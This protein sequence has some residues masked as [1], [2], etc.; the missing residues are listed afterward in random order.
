[1]EAPIAIGDTETEKALYSIENDHG[2]DTDKDGETPR[3]APIEEAIDELDEL[4]G[5]IEAIEDKNNTVLNESIEESDSDSDSDSDSEVPILKY[6]RIKKLPPTLFNKDPISTCTFHESYFLFATH[7]GKIHIT[8]PT[9]EPLRNFKA[10]R[11]SILSLYT[12]GEYFASGSMDGTVV[13]GSIKDESDITA[14]DFQRPI[15]GVILDPNY[16]RTK[17]FITGGMSGKV[18]YSTWNWLGKRQDLVIEEGS[19]PIVSL[20]LVN[21]MLI[22]MNDFGITICQFSTRRVVKKIEKPEDSPRSDLYWPKVSFPEIDRILI[23]WGNYIWMLRISADESSKDDESLALKILPS[24]ASFRSVVAERK[25]VTVDHIYKL[26][27]LIS[28]ITSFKDDLWMVLTYEPPSTEDGKR[29]FHNPEIKLINSING[30]VEFEEEVGMNNIENLGLND[31]MIRS[32]IHS[33]GSPTSYYIISAK[34]GIVV[35][36]YQLQ[37]ILEWYI[38][39]GKY[40]EAWEISIHLVGW[41]KRLGYGINHVD[42]LIKDDSWSAAAQFLTSLLSFEGLEEEGEEN[43]AREEEMI[44]NWESFGNIFIDSGHIKE[45]SDVIPQRF[46][47]SASIYNKILEYCLEE[48]P[49]K[50]YKSIQ[51]DIYLYDIKKIQSL[52]E[53]KLEGDEKNKQLRRCLTDLYDKSNDYNKAVP[54]LIALKDWNLV[55]YLSKNHILDAYVDMLPKII[56]LRFTED[57]LTSDRL[58]IKEIEDRIHDIIIILLSQVHLKSR[59]LELFKTDMDFVS[60]LYFK[61]EK[62]QELSKAKIDDESDGYEDTRIILYSKYNKQLLLPYLKE[63]GKVINIESSIQLFQR[64]RYWEE[65]IYLYEQ[66]GEIDKCVEIIIDELDD[67]NLI[68]KFLNNRRSRN[69]VVSEYTQQQEVLLWNQLIDKSIHKPKFIKK[70]LENLVEEQ[71][72]SIDIINKLKEINLNGLNSSI[73][74]IYDKMEMN[75]LM[76]QVILKLINYNSSFLSGDYREKMLVG[77]EI[78]LGENNTI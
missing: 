22:W 38:S 71:Y 64:L 78:T 32:I 21:D 6:N 3:N 12:D 66:I 77:V 19:G 40:F 10:H 75:M 67:E 17:G 2:I 73:I 41:K 46:Q 39:K 63:K 70:L 49:V 34:D 72:Y 51:W 68:I 61:E 29:V 15:H 58:L 57:E 4:T 45:L 47:I 20:Q 5:V 16:S 44:K 31:Y 8:T 7:T 9:F 62:S 28:G 26:D 1:M 56:K 23:G 18:T 52:I 55:E 27:S 53:L 69:K 24:S 36:E 74:T 37:D 25:Q 35:Q 33:D 43:E 50:F 42:N 59:I 13:I 60:Y 65:L 14:F 76:N 48:E 30:E 11:A 54:H